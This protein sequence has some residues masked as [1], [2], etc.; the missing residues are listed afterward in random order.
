M[1][2]VMEAVQNMSTEEKFLVI[3]ML[4]RDIAASNE[5]YAPQWHFDVL[6]EREQ[7]LAD[8]IAKLLDWG[9]VKAELQSRRVVS[10]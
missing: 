2:A 1:P 5:E 6:R 4:W 3:D 7:S 9:D 8:G 10:V